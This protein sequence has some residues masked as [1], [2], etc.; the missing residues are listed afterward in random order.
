MRTA[1]CTLLCAALTGAGAYPTAP[2]VRA[3]GRRHAI[4]AA[5]AAALPALLR[6]VPPARAEETISVYFGA[7]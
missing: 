3:K 7:G 2:V 1:R 4:A 5:A 6:G